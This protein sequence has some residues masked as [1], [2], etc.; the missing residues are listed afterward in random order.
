MRAIYKINNDL[1]AIVLNIL[2]I[3]DTATD[4]HLDLDKII[5][6]EEEYEE[7]LELGNV[8][9]IS[10]EPQAIITHNHLTRTCRIE[11]E[12]CTQYT[13]THTETSLT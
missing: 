10:G 3:M 4:A 11:I 1:P 8:L 2:R 7:L 6:T 9:L 12:P 5:L 13:Q